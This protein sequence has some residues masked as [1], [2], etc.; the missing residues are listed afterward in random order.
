MGKYLDGNGLSHL[1]GMI[2][3]ALSGKA[4]SSDLDDL[5]PKQPASSDLPAAST[6]N[7]LFPLM[8]GNTFAN[9][10]K[11]SY[12]TKANFQTWLGW[13]DK[14]DASDLGDY[15]PLTGG[16]LSGSVQISNASNKN[17]SEKDTTANISLANNGYSSGTRYMEWL[18]YD[19][20][21]ARRA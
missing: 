11:V 9:S 12:L 17:W 13:S 6:S 5:L 10:G 15:L 18:A 3:T 14:A 1:I 8:L 21:S 7:T 16:T 20:N 4:D 19:K 2:K